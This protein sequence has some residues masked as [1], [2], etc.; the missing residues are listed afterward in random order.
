MDIKDLDNFLEELTSL[1]LTLEIFEHDIKVTVIRNTHHHFTFI[2]QIITL[3]CV[4]REM[5][6]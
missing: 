5:E 3:Y 1:A 2:I 6:E 4:C